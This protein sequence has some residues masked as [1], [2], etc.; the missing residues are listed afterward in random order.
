MRRQ[1]KSGKQGRESI[2]ESKGNPRLLWRIMAA[3][4]PAQIEFDLN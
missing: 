4:I 2:A 1:K 3:L